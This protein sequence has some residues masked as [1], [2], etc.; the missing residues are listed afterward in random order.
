MEPGEQYLEVDVDA[1]RTPTLVTVR[2]EL[3]AAS[4][5][6]LEAAFAAAVAGADL[7]LDLSAVTFIDSSGLRAI[8]AARR[9]AEAGGRSLEVVSASVAVRRIFEMTGLASLLA[10]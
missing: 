5:P 1:D 6:Q 8:T 7:A 4:A 3:D 2:G 9:E 10:G